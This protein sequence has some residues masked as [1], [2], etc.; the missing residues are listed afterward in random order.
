MTFFG[1]DLGL[2]RCFR[3]VLR[4]ELSTRIGRRGSRSVAAR[5]T[6]RALGDC[7]NRSHDS[8]MHFKDGTETSPNTIGRRVGRLKC[9]LRRSQYS[10]SH[11]A[12]C[13][14]STEPL[15]MTPPWI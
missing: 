8:L 3:Q 4:V 2:P 15:V 5:P 9:L 13:R 6:L 14:S 12:Q 1:A 10:S 11:A 7:Q